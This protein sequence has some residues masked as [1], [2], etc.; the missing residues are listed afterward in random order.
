M[1]PQTP[2]SIQFYHYQPDAEAQHRPQ[3]MFTPQPQ[4]APMHMYA[5]PHGMYYPQPQVWQQPPFQPHGPYMGHGVMTP[6]ASPPA[7][8]FA[9]KIFVDQHHS[10]ALQPIETNFVV[11]SRHSPAPPT[12]SLSACPSAISSPPASSAFQTPVNS[13]FFTIPSLESLESSKDNCPEM[14]IAPFADAEWNMSEYAQC[15]HCPLSTN[16]QDVFDQSS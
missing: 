5:M 14:H 16:V 3:A 9:P 6:V 10:P 7:V 13:G 11:E 15:K 2:G 8:H 1:P 4:K 12:P